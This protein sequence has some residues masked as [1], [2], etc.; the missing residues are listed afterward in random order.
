VIYEVK[1]SLKS[2]EISLSNGLLSIRTLETSSRQQ[3]SQSF[4]RN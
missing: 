1:T 4:Q 2:T 3:L